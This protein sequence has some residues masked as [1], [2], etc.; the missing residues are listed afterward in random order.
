M[1]VLSVLLRP[2][3]WFRRPAQTDYEEVLAGLTAD[4][5]SVQTNLVQIQARKRRATLIL[6]FWASVLWLVWTALAW[7]LGQL[8]F[9]SEGGASDNLM[10][11][12]GPIIGAPIL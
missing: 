11:V 6:P 1:T 12:W 5:D 3:A 7:W 10:L 2:M 4:I 9:G 8:G